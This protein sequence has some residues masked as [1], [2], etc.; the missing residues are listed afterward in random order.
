MVRS[1]GSGVR[2]LAARSDVLIVG[3]GPAGSIAALVLARAGVSVT[4]L[5]RAVFPRDKLCGDSVNPGA[6]ALLARHG[7][8]T[9]VEAGGLP[10]SGMLV[11]GPGEVAVHARYPDGVVGRSIPR[12]DFD[13]LLLH[14]ASRAGARVEQG[15][16]VAGPIVDGS[17]GAMRVTGVST[18]TG[19]GAICRPARVV[20]AA[21]GRRSTLALALGLARHPHRP[22][23]WAVGA[24]F[25]GVTG[26]TDVGEMHVRRGHYVGVAPVTGGLANACL[27]VPEAR[28][29]A[30][31]SASTEALERAVQGDEQ[32]GPRFR[33]AR[34][35]T[36]VSMMGPLAVDVEGAGVE[37]LLLAGDAAGF[38]DPMTGDG[39]RLA[40]RGGELAAAAALESLEGR[41]NAHLRL[42]DRRGRELGIKQRVNRLIRSLVAEPMGVSAAALA[43]AL[44]PSALARLI[45][46]AGDIN[47]RDS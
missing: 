4:L 23:R 25:E 6:M 10:V 36:P 33:S 22:R 34:R 28:A 29:R 35:T 7:L 46:Y 44:W 8:A 27:V 41:P 30:I 9:E 45:S 21:D 31:G 42:A 32:L 43:A 13:A 2:G 14:A 15:V 16:R 37:G 47:L 19:N 11:T 3:G 24:Y 38:I 5:D 12:R 17:A 1:P 18:Q 39:L 20:I 40:M 26:L